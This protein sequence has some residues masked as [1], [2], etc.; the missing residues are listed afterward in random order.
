MVYYTQKVAELIQLAQQH[1]IPTNQ[2]QE[3]PCRGT[4]EA[5]SCHLSR[6]HRRK[7]KE[8][9]IAVGSGSGTKARYETEVHF[10]GPQKIITKVRIRCHKWAPDGFRGGMGRIFGSD[11]VLGRF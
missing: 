11:Q 1:N 9:N 3:R 4:G 2:V 10:L 5:T 8:R 7:G 6:N